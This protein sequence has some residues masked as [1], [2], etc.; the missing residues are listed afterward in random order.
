M[1]T[2]MYVLNR[3]TGRGMWR[4]SNL[5]FWLWENQDNVCLTHEIQLKYW[6]ISMVL[7]VWSKVWD[8]SSNSLEQN[9]SK[10]IQEKLN[11]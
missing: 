8:L 11:V 7:T 9:Q 1:E 6:R 10:F 5:K 3:I 4:Q 2:A